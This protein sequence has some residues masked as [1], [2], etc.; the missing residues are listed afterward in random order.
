MARKLIVDTGLLIRS[1]RSGAPFASALRPDDDVAIA[2]ITVAELRLGVE[3]ASKRHRAAR[4]A[5]VSSILVRLPVL[6]YDAAIAQVHA[7]LL[8]EVRRQGAPRGS[9]D[10][11]IAA[12]AA[13][14]SRT[15]LTTD[16]SARFAS[17]TGV[18]CI[19]V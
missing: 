3:L 19:V 16:H 6:D 14:S 10:L 12:T 15:I 17:L 5:F 18:N 1:E 2:A 8:A 4:E 7:R 13:A 9:H 11:F